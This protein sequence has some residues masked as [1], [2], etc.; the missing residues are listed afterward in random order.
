MSEFFFVRTG[1]QNIGFFHPQERVASF[2]PDFLFQGSEVINALE[3]GRIEVREDRIACH[4]VAASQFLLHGFE[5]PNEILVVNEKGQGFCH[6][7]FDQGF[8]HEDA[9]S[10]LRSDR[11]VGDSP[12]RDDDQPVEGDLLKG[13]NFSAAPV[14]VRIKGG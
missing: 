1:E 10:L 5:P 11:A 13:T 6:V 3:S 2:L 12:S 4:E 9:V 7:S 8:L 14:P